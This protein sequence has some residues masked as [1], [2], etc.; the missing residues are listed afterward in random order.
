MIEDMS[1]RNLAPRTEEAYIRCK[2]LAAFLGRSP[3]AA[4]AEGIRSFQLHLAE[5][6][7]SIC[8]RNRTMTGSGVCSMPRLASSAACC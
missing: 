1:L 2:K 5:Q 4:T 6:G 8:S 3:D 7:V